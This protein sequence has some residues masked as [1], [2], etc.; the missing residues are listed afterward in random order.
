M[1]SILRQ[2]S[3]NFNDFS[4]LLFFLFLL[5]SSIKPA[6][7]RRKGA[8]IIFWSLGIYSVVNFLVIVITINR[9]FDLSMFLAETPN[10]D[11]D[12]IS[13]RAIGLNGQP[14]KLALFSA[15]SIIIISR[16]SNELGLM[17]RKVWLPVFVVLS[18]FNSVMSFSRIGIV[19][20]L[21][22]FLFVSRRLKLALSAFIVIGAVFTVNNHPEKIK[23]LFRSDSLVKVNASSLDNRLVL[24]REA[25][26]IVLKNP[27]NFMF[28]FGPSKKHADKIQ[29]PIKHHSLRY[30]DSSIT[31]V[32]FRYGIFSLVFS[33]LFFTRRY[34]YGAIKNTD[35]RY[36]LLLFFIIIL[37]ASLDPIFHDIKL[38]ILLLFMSQ[39]SQLSLGKYVR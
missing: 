22:S 5:T 14:G 13:L 36:N 24:R 9:I 15:F 20:T 1:F 34:L 12:Y 16:L 37:S 17:T 33:I 4:D 3:L 39:M 6:Y 35:F 26:N 7:N 2:R 27:I 21:I 28:G 29:L 19:I 25:F 31:L 32:A 10:F 8:S 38:L 11:L 23:L 18:A 30:P